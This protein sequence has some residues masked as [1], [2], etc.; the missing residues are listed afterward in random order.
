MIL[1]EIEMNLNLRKNNRK[2]SELMSMTNGIDSNARIRI[3]WAAF[4]CSK[5]WLAS[6]RVRGLFL[7][8][9]EMKS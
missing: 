3:L 7:R 9:Q 8:R 1:L 4:L 5:H 6:R 2:I